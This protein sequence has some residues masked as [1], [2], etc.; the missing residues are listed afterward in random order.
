MTTHDMVLFAISAAINLAIFGLAYWWGRR[1][2]KANEGGTP[3]ATEE[4][5][6]RI[7]IAAGAIQLLKRGCVP[8]F[9]QPL[10]WFQF[11]SHKLLRWFSPVLF[12]SLLFTNMLLV[13]QHWI[14]QLTMIVQCLGYLALLTPYLLPPIRKTSLGSVLFYTALGQ[15]GMTVGLFRGLLNRQSPQWDKGRRIEEITGSRQ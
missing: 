6:R 5:R 1:D 15:V 12:S 14:Y 7:R 2:A 13:S 11:F 4:F 3:T 10:V 9:D 8:R